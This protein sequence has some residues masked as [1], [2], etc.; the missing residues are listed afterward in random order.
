VWQRK[1]KAQVRAMPPWTISGLDGTS[2]RRSDSVSM[3]PLIQDLFIKIIYLVILGVMLENHYQ[4]A[5]VWEVKMTA[6]AAEISTAF[7][8]KMVLEWAKTRRN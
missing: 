8:P 7:P 5:I 1:S 2:G 6:T 4:K 3:L